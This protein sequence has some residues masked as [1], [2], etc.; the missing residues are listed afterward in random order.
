L[1]TPYAQAFTNP[2]W[3]T[4]GDRPIR[5]RSAAEYSIQWI[6]KLIM[7]AEAWPGWRSQRERDHVF[8]QFDEA[9]RIYQR[10]AAEDGD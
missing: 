1:D 10:L 4:V 7:F 8:G 2:V 6:E 9:K 3:I 5:D